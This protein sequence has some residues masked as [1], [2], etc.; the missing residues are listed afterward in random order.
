MADL[1]KEAKKANE[2]LTEI[3]K[4]AANPSFKIALYVLGAAAV[5][6]LIAL[7]IIFK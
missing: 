7:L 4:L 6:G 3:G 2:D 5:L 1:G